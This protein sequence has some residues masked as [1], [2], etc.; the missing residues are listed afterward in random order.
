MKRLLTAMMVFFVLFLNGCNVLSQYSEPDYQVLLSQGNIEVREYQ[1]SIVAEV[2]VSGERDQAI[3]DGFR[4][5]AGYIFGNNTTVVSS[6][7]TSE[8]IAM[9][10]PVMQQENLKIPMTTPVMQVGNDNLWTVQFVMPKDYTLKTL[11]RPNNKNIK[12]HT[13]S[14]RQAV[15]IRFSGRSSQANLDQH[16]ATLKEYIAKNKLK[17]DLTPVYAFYNPPWTLPFLRR[18]EIIFQ[19]LRSSPK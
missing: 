13:I 19:L 17:T 15:A 5:L 10:T 18:N 7:E 9:T 6:N 14:K 2:E 1:P 3:R 11:P 4:Q 16:L 8:K 12:L